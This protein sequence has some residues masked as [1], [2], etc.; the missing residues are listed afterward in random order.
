[1]VPP[2]MD[3]TLERWSRSHACALL[4]ASGVALLTGHVWPAALAGT[5]S[6]ALLLRGVRGAFT[7]GGG[8]GSANLVT[9]LRLAIVLGLAFGA[10]AP[11]PLVA[12]AVLAVFLLDGLDG[13]LARRSGVASA[14]GAHFDMEVDAFLVLVVELVL[15]QRGFGIWILTTGLLRYAYVIALAL[16]PAPGGE[17]PRSR[18]GRLAFGTLVLGLAGAAVLP[19]AAAVAVAGFGT[20]LVSASFVRG[21][22][23]SYRSLPAREPLP[24]AAA[25]G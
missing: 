1:M 9:S 18:F 7:P 6:F 20:L 22:H 3:Q 12:A 2:P 19:E 15:W 11:A 25:D 16:V 5:L 4:C 13:W 8:F 10:R 24:G 23:W 21:L 17:Q 14:F